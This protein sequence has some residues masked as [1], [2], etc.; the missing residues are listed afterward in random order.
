MT[1]IKAE[2]HAG[3]S[4]FHGWKC[5]TCGRFNWWGGLD[6]GKGHAADNPNHLVRLV[7]W[8]YAEEAIP[9]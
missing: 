9:R 1:E 7:C 6:Q 5:D 4:W 8:K 3:N 2:Y